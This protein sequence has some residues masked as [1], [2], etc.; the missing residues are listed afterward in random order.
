MRQVNETARALI[1]R[2]EGL[3]DGVK[4]TPA[5]EPQLC[6]AGYWTVGYGHALKRPDGSLFK[7]AATKAE[8]MA[9]WRRRWPGGMTRGDAD[10]LL[11]IDLQE[12]AA[13]VAPL[14]PERLTDNQFGA[15]VSFAYNLGVGAL[16][17]S[18]LLKRLKM[19]DDAG[20]ANQFLLWD[21]ATDPAT[22]RKV[23]LAGLT[24]RRQ[25]ERALFLS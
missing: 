5:L 13:K 14:A 17:G 21:K 1:Q 11:T 8:A 24:H 10:A 4:T 23:V 9:E 18:T 12:F 6:P 22:G 19:G 20:A 16:A 15:L 25:A 2:F 3:H 7:G